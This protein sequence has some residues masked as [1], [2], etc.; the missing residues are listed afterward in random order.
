MA[1]ATASSR[2]TAQLDGDL[3]DALFAHEFAL[4]RALE[5]LNPIVAS[6]DIRDDQLRW[7]I[8]LGSKLGDHLRQLRAAGICDEAEPRTAA[9]LDRARGGGQ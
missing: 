5:G 4:E 6:K 2:F 7:A 3:A 9:R 8:D 1:A